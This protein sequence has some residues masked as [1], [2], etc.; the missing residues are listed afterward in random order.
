[1]PKPGSVLH[2]TVP[3]HHL[4]VALS[5]EL[6]DAPDFQK[7]LSV[8]AF[9]EGWALYAESLGAALGVYREPATRFGQLASERFRVFERR[10]LDDV[11]REQR[12]SDADGD[13]IARARYIV[14]GSVS[15]LGS[16]DK[17]FGALLAGFGSA[18]LEALNDAGI[19][20][21]PIERLGIP[22]TF[23]EHGAQ[24]LLRAKYGLDASAIA[25]AALHLL[26]VSAL[27][28]ISARS[29]RA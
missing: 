25:K 27:P 11:S 26:Q 29:Q 22:D 1:M 8:R 16:N 2:E 12:L 23:V 14:T 19:S 4:R 15:Q 20:H 18:V 17:N 6:T 21:L 13:S 7:A 5:R 28:C 10:L 24:S 9:A 3:G